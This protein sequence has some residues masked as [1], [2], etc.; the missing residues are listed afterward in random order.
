[1]IVVADSTVASLEFLDRLDVLEN[2]D[3]FFE[4]ADIHLLNLRAMTVSQL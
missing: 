3:S 1:V 4:L 2:G